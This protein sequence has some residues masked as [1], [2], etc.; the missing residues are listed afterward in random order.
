MLETIIYQSSNPQLKICPNKYLPWLMHLCAS[1]GDISLLNEHIS[2][3]T[4][5]WADFFKP[6]FKHVINKL[7]WLTNT[8]EN[9]W[10]GNLA[11]SLEVA[12]GADKPTHCL[13]G[14][15]PFHS[16]TLRNN[17]SWQER[18]SGDVKGTF[19]LRMETPPESP[20]CGFSAAG[21]ESS[22]A[23]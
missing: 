10:A 6:H 18:K 11:P 21:G 19:C 5:C 23:E 8:P 22:C 14:E 9:P 3:M 17:T 4:L 2:N 20:P 13:P 16:P 7:R 15:W 12:H 1:G